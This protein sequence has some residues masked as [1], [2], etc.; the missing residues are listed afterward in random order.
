MAAI[1][2]E[3]RERWDFLF[4][5]LKQRIAH[6]SADHPAA[7]VWK[8]S[9]LV[10][11]ISK[12]RRGHIEILKTT[13]PR[14][15]EVIER[16]QKIGWLLPIEVDSPAE[17]S[18]QVLYLL[19]ME[20]T[21][22]DLPEVLELL[23]GYQSNGVLSYF[24][25]LAYHELTTQLPSFAHIGILQD[26]AATE[27]TQQS[28]PPSSVSQSPPTRQTSPAAKDSSERNPLGSP[29]FSYQSITCYSTKRDRALV[30]GIQT[31][32]VGPRTHLRMTTLEQTLL[33]S[34]FYPL[35]CGGEA[36]VFEAWER[37]MERCN[38]DRLRQHLQAIDRDDFDRRV[39]AMLTLLDYDLPRGSLQ[40]HLDAA[41]LRYQSGDSTAPTIPLLKG[42][43]Y[44]RT[45]PEW[46]VTVP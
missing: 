17:T 22:E 2:K 36:V 35:H 43:T 4:R 5:E 19:D 10:S 3:L 14:A 33:D 30:P 27:S 31:R 29:I 1:N 46:G 7:K 24:A 23:Q 26:Y 42:L 41:A 6:P 44:S 28:T 13:F 25:V 40:A 12:L 18:T 34:L 20:A 15:K 39:G 8:H 21:A 9:D 16:M 32:E 45:I 37:G 38:L 11:V